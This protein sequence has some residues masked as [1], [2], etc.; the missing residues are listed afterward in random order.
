MALYGEEMN[1]RVWEFTWIM[2]PPLVTQA[3]PDSRVPTRFEESLC[4][5]DT[6]ADQ[7]LVPVAFRTR[8]TPALFA[9]SFPARSWRLNSLTTKSTNTRVFA[10]SCRCP[11]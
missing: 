11:A 6:V 8:P 1:S 2:C 5:F 3:P 7:G 4:A 10:G 9:S